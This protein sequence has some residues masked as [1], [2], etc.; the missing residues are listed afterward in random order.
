M[1]CFTPRAILGP[2]AASAL[3]LAACGDAPDP[4]ATEPA[5][6]SPAEDAMAAIEPSVPLV[7]SGWVRTPP[8]GRDVTA[9][10]MTLLAETEDD[11]LIGARSPAAAAIEL[12]TMEDDGEVMRMRQ[13]EAIDLPAGE[14]VSLRPGGDHLMFFGVDTASLDGEVEITLEFA[15]GA[16][17]TIRL[18]L[19][20]T[21]PQADAPASTDGHGGMDHSAM[22]HGDAHQRGD[23]HEPVED[24][25]GGEEE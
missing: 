2:V 12:H 4:A 3:L 24:E 1:I 5:A 9:G 23:Y 17:T 6:P 18:P 21:P 10:Y 8:A 15:S 13:V 11:Q 19:S 22:D 20:A 25:D 14:P 7:T 16:E